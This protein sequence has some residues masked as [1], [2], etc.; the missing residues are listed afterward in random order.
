MNHFEYKGY[1]GSVKVSVAD[2]CM[3]GKIEFINDLVNYE[4]ETVEELKKEFEASVERYLEH[5]KLVGKEPNKPF[6]GTFNIRIGHELHEKSAKRAEEIG[7]SLNDYIKD[8]IKKDIES[9]A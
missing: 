6:K 7:K 2:K 1:L 5:C 8:T 4:A 3:H 9:H